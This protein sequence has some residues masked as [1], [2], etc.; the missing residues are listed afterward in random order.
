M[1]A[2]TWN[3]RVKKGGLQGKERRGRKEDNGT[4][5]R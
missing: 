1:N 5:M 4:D 2:T 3:G